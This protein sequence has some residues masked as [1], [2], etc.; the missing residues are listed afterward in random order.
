MTNAANV[1]FIVNKLLVFLENSTDEHFRS[2]LVVRITQ[3][4]ET[5]APSN[6]WYVKT[7]IKVFELAGDRVKSSVTET[8][9]QLIAEGSGENTEE[10]DEDLRVFVV[11]DF[12]ELIENTKLPALLAQTVAWV[13]GEYGFTSISHDSASIME[14]LVKLVDDITDAGTRAHIVSALIKLVAQNGGEAT[15]S[16]SNLIANLSTSMHSDVQQR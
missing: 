6:T 4:A 5:F 2:D 15:E 7:M 14:K 10:D 11:E 1:E 3:C 16:V 9:M 13:L 8:L 12:L